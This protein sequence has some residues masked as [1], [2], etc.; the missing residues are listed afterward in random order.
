LLARQGERKICIADSAMN[1]HT[2]GTA[3][4]GRFRIGDRFAYRV[5]D[6]L[7]KLQTRRFT[8]TVTA[9]TASEVIFNNGRVITDLLGSARR[10]SRFLRGNNTRCAPQ[11]EKAAS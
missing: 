3:S 2:K 10:W 9:I 4:A 1:P 11:E 6:Q 8:R 7:T 5:E